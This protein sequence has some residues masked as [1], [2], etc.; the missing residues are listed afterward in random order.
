MKNKTEQYFLSLLTQ[1]NEEMKNP[2]PESP[3]W[4]ENF[5]L[6]EEGQ[7]CE[8]QTNCMLNIVL[9]FVDFSLGKLGFSMKEENPAIHWKTNKNLQ[10][11]LWTTFI[12]FI[13]YG[14]QE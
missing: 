10:F 14:E 2:F 6:G 13:S 1:V 8:I 9:W 11:Q 7:V 3:A 4:L 12:F 5:P